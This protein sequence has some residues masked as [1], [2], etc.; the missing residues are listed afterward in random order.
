MTLS[1]GVLRAIERATGQSIETLQ[2]TPIGE[3]RR[4][5]EARLG[6][7]LRIGSCGPPFVTRE[8]LEA[9]LAGALR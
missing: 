5:T 9:G 7:P 4:R 3:L 1:D 6:R 8:Q 2:S